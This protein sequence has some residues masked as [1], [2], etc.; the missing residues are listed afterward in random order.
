MVMP[1]GGSTLVC[2]PLEAVL[3]ALLYSVR[4]EQRKTTKEA[5]GHSLPH[6]LVTFRYLRSRNKVGGTALRVVAGQSA[7]AVAGAR[8][9]QEAA[10][11]REEESTRARGGA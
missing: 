8:V 9:E 3:Q 1:E 5:S 6:E 10:L 7:H 11:L 4:R 2:E